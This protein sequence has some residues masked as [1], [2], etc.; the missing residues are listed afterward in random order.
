MWKRY[1]CRNAAFSSTALKQALN[2]ALKPALKRPLK[3][4]SMSVLAL[5]KPIGSQDWLRFIDCQLYIVP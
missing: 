5:A 2:Q 1:S 4:L 3:M